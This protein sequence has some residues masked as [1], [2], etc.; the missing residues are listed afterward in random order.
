MSRT[1][2]NQQEQTVMRKWLS[3][4]TGLTSGPGPRTIEGMGSH[5]HTGWD[6]SGPDKLIIKKPFQEFTFIFPKA[7]GGFGLLIRVLDGGVLVELGHTSGFR[8]TLQ[9]VEVFRGGARGL[10]TAGKSTGPHWHVQFRRPGTNDIL[11]LP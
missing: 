11:L 3:V 2:A 9:G 6:F 5:Y 1:V 4:F 8:E 10:A 7:S